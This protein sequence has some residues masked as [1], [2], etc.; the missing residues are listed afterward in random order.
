MNF[1]ISGR[2]QENGRHSVSYPSFPSYSL[3]QC[4]RLA[5]TTHTGSTAPAWKQHSGS[6]ACSKKNT[7]K[8]TSLFFKE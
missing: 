5:V 2:G 4:E 1:Y 7:E 3:S 6:Q 8:T